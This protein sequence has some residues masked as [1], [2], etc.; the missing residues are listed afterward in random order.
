MLVIEA[1]H[2]GKDKGSSSS[3]IFENDLNVKIV[4]SAVEVIKEN[5][6]NYIW[7][8]EK[9]E[10]IDINNRGKKLKIIGDKFGKCDVFS[11]HCDWDENSSTEGISIIKSVW[12][13][14]NDDIYYEFMKKIEKMF[15]IKA[16]K[17]WSRNYKDGNLKLDHYGIMR[18]SGENCSVKI[19]EV[20]F[21]S[22]KH[23]KEIIM[24]NS[25]E[26]GCEIGKFILNKNG[27]EI[28]NK[29]LYT[30]QVGAF[31]SLENAKKMQ[32]DLKLKGFESIIKGL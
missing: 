3:G 22:N 17:V 19:M 8:N 9:N 15:G 18:L 30:V 5:T 10:Y 14:E 24:K 27:I 32:N 6:T 29:N 21:I 28:K 16:R 2:G 26:I 20:G 25:K 7:F 4:K 13:T 31:N 12:N 1:G 11:I 23:D